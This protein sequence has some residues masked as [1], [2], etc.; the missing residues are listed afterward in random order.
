QAGDKNL[1][2]SQDQ[3]NLL[4]NSMK[5]YFN[6]AITKEEL[7]NEI[8]SALNKDNVSAMRAVNLSDEKEL[9]EII[10]KTQIIEKI[11]ERIEKY[12]IYVFDILKEGKRVLCELDVGD[13]NGFL[14]FDGNFIYGITKIDKHYGF[15][16]INRDDMS[17]VSGF[18]N[19]TVICYDKIAQLSL[20][21]V[22]E[23]KLI[24]SS[25]KLGKNEIV[26]LDKNI[27][28]ECEIYKESEEEMAK[29]FMLMNVEGIKMCTELKSS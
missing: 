8:K 21:E 2:I 1:S 18:I 7:K 3:K 20:G 9:D 29:L 14:L 27:S 4:L 15:I 13:K 23:Y 26:I 22:L 17:Y 16:K 19:D 12:S 10:E 24:A 25:L 28:I 5:K 6:G 11:K